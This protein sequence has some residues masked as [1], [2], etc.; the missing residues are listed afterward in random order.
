MD[1]QE[2]VY[3]VV[4]PELGWRW[5]KD[6]ASLVFK[7]PGIWIGTSLIMMI[8]L[9]VL[10]RIPIV[11]WA[12]P[13]LATLLFGGLMVGCARQSRGGDLELEDL[14]V[15]FREPHMQPLLM[16]GAAMLLLRLACY[17]VLWV[18]A[19]VMG[20]GTVLSLMMGNPLALLSSGLVLLVWVVVAV[21]LLSAL[22]LA[23]MFAPALS[24]LGGVPAATALRASFQAALANCKPLTL[25]GVIGAALLI[26]AAMTVLG[27]LV[28]V[29]I[30]IASTYLAYR[31]IFASQP[32]LIPAIDE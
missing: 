8:I 24:A 17:A 2:P 27:L 6:G 10:G 15:G 9:G 1:T 31:D 16:L 20:V 12:S 11:S 29:P 30:A 25:Y 14:F 7:Q 19:M 22:S 23:F 4:A 3:Q 18:L 32:D 21:T 26:L 28:A 13:V 5:I